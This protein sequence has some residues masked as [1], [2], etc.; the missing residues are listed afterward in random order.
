MVWIPAERICRVRSSPDRLPARLANELYAAGESGMGYHAFSVQ[1]RDGRRL[2]FVSGNA[3]DFPAW[4]EGVTGADAVTVKRHDRHPSIG[5]GRRGP[6]SRTLHTRG[7]RF[8]QMRRR[9]FDLRLD[10]SPPCE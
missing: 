4:P 9:I 10:F 8:G 1:L 2:H 3:V 7:A 5:N 6:T